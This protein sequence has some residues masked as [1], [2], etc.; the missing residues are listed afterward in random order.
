VGF[1]AAAIS[2]SS[3]SLGNLN[4]YWAYHLGPIEIA[5]KLHL[6]DCAKFGDSAKITTAP[7][8]AYSKSNSLSAIENLC[9]IE[10]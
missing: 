7:T 2:V 6:T 10:E 3:E 9:A 8:I 5:A 4:K 1:V